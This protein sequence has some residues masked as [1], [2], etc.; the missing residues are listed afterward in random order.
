MSNTIITRKVLNIPVLAILQVVD[1]LLEHEIAHEI[2][3][4]DEEEELLIIQVE[5]EKHIQ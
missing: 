2:V 1:L 5:Y 3:A 4:T